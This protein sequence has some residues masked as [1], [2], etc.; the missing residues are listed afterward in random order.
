VHA[1]HPSESLH[2]LPPALASRVFAEGTRAA[3]KLLI[4]DLRRPPSLLLILKLA[5]R[6][7]FTPV[8]PA[9]HDGFISSLRAY[10]PSA[11][12]ALAR[13][14]DPAITVELRGGVFRPQT[15]WPAGCVAV[16]KPVA[17]ADQGPQD[18]WV[19]LPASRRQY[20]CCR[21]AIGRQRA[22]EPRVVAGRHPM[23]LSCQAAIALRCAQAFVLVV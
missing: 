7:P 16:G 13:H 10:S 6:L 3:H 8:I 17:S 14:A 18:R 15:C 5:L 20:D 23:V 2:H 1:R 19:M 4:I 11:L 9:Q 21:T 12:R 22:Q